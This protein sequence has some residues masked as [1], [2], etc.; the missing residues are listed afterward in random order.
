MRKSSG[1]SY[2]S[3]IC[4]ALKRILEKKTLGHLL[5]HELVHMLTTLIRENTPLEMTMGA[6]NLMIFD[7]IIF[8][9]VQ[10]SQ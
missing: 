10:L 9:Y 8:V 7:R 1:S 6:T 5:H 2:A 3:A 4:S